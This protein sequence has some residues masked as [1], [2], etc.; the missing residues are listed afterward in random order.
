[1]GIETSRTVDELYS[2]NIKFLDSAI[3]EM[4]GSNSLR[5]LASTG[6]PVDV[7]TWLRLANMNHKI[8]MPAMI[9]RPKAVSEVRKD[10]N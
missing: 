8:E 4:R 9:K 5:K 1:L 10:K 3:G 2:Q 7:D 6:K